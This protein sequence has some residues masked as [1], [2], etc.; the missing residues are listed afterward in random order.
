[1]MMFGKEKE[2]RECDYNFGGDRR[3]ICGAR[4]RR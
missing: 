2:V 3:R 4:P 1:M